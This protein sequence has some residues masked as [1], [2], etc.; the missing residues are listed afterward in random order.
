MVARP[1][2]HTDW[3]GTQVEPDPGDKTAGLSP[4][5]RPA[6]QWLNF[7]FGRADLWT[8]YA[9]A[10][11]S[12]VL[13]G[14]GVRGFDPESEF[15]L[16]ASQSFARYLGLR[17]E[18]NAL[19][20]PRLSADL[21]TAHNAFACDGERLIVAVGDGGQIV[22]SDDFGRTW[23]SQTADDSFSGNFYAAA[24]ANGVFVIAG[25]LGELQT[26]PDGVT[27]TQR[28]SG[29]GSDTIRQLAVRGSDQSI[30]AIGE[31][32]VWTRSIDSFDTSPTG[33]TVL[34][35]SGYTI[36][37]G[38]GRPD[39][40]ILVGS[41]GASDRTNYMHLSNTGSSWSAVDLTG[42]LGANEYPD[43]IEHHDTLGYV[44]TV[45]DLSTLRYTAVL[46]SVDGLTWTRHDGLAA[47]AKESSGVLVA[48]PGGVLLVSVHGDEPTAYSLDLDAWRTVPASVTPGFGLANAVT[49][50]SL[51]SC[52]LW[53]GNVDNGAGGRL[54]VSR[55]WVY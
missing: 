9:D 19:L 2:S 27:W 29:F 32:G 28:T 43:Q 25:V 11:A 15:T 50:L 42:V 1:T 44:A 18:V 24:Y 55:P 49:F 5:D 39:A 10:I 14:L 7:L 47:V 54:F 51:R 6:A 17:Q 35:G 26:S 53:A 34:V 52:Q 12:D 38:V 41:G 33:G 3:Q 45:Y 16:N 40:F 48:T 46:S 21:G 31:N 4:G 20:D 30:V 37:D 13:A 8:K 23:T 22:T 36:V